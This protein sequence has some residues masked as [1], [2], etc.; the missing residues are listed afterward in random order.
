MTTASFA[1]Q[2]LESGLIV[3]LIVTFACHF[4]A[5]KKQLGFDIIDV[6]ER[7]GDMA[8]WDLH[9]LFIEKGV[10]IRKRQ[11]L[12]ICHE[13]E[14]RGCIESDVDDSHRMG[15]LVF[16]TRPGARHRWVSRRA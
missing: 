2:L 4:R 9:K 11:F 12:A 10:C 16:R 5:R 14:T 8:S 3:Y 1:S 13:L 7:K 6:L 15:D